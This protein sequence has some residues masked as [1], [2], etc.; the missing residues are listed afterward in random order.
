[1]GRRNLQFVDKKKC[2]H[3]CQIQSKPLPAVAVIPYWRFSKYPIHDSS[4]IIS[5]FSFFRF[6]NFVMHL[7]IIYMHSKSYKSRKTKI[8]NNLGWS[9]SLPKQ[10]STPFGFGYVRD[11]K[12]YKQSTGIGQIFRTCV[13]IGCTFHILQHQNCRSHGTAVPL[14]NLPVGSCTCT[15]RMC[16]FFIV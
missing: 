4:Q 13:Q 12:F 1:M 9:S 5:R 3:P 16:V 7:D 2:I 11:I 6:I 8:T 10:G 15:V 14:C